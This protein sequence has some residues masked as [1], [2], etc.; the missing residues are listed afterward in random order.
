MKT[1]TATVQE[2]VATK[3]D[4]SLVPTEDS[5]ASPLATKE[6]YIILSQSGSVL[7]RFLK[8]VTRAP[9][10]HAS[11][12]LQGDLHTMY[13]FGRIR[14]YNP[15]VGGFVRESSSFGTFKRFKKTRIRVL[16]IEVSLEAYNEASRIIEQMLGEQARYRYNYWGLILAAIRVPFKKRYR[17]YCSEFVKYVAVC[18]NLPEAKA[19][20]AIVKPMHLLSLPHQIIYEGILCEYDPQLAEGLASHEIEPRP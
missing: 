2:P 14:P 17:Y 8:L 4:G 3:A 18:M 7:S 20:P 12:A 16:K 13:S 9:Y 11:I 19:L 1:L 15:F 5:A 10:N 6:I